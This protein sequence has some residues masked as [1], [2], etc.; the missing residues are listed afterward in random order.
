MPGLLESIVALCVLSL[1]LTAT[2]EDAPTLDD[3][4]LASSGWL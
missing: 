1:L 3:A 2:S 4:A